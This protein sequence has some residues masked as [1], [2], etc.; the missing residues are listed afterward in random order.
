[1]KYVVKGTRR[2]IYG[3]RNIILLYVGGK[4]SG[5]R[6]RERGSEREKKQNI[7]ERH[8]KSLTGKVQ[9]DR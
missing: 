6:N 2:G 1:M 5:M 3:N 8:R 7:I 4:E 9:K